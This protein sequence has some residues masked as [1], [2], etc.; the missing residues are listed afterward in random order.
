MTMRS[1]RPEAGSATTMHLTL[2]ALPD[3][4]RGRVSKGVGL[5]LRDG[6]SAPSA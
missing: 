1:S 4:I 3:H 5:M 6:H 2:R